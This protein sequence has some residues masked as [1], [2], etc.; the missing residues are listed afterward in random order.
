MDATLLSGMDS[1]LIDSTWVLADT[2]AKQRKPFLAYRFDPDYPKPRTALLLSFAIPGAG[3]FYN[4]R[5]W[6]VPIVYGALGSLG[7][8]I[9]R[10]SNDYL[11]LKRAHRRKLRGVPHDFSGISY[12]DDAGN[13]KDLRDQADRNLQLSYVG[14]FVVYILNGAEAFV[15]AHLYHF[16]VDEDLSWRLEPSLIDSPYGATTGVGLKI[17]F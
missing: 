1:L 17:R 10:N 5:W 16:N 11:Q 6:K 2:T 7:Y 14:F 12:L 13:L 9:H 15:D 8:L 4:G 3:Q